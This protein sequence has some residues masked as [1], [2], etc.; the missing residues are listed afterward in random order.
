VVQHSISVIPRTVNLRHLHENSAV[1]LRNI[2]NLNDNQVRTVALSVEAMISE[3]DLPD[4]AFVKIAFHA[5]SKDV[6]LWWYDQE[7]DGEIQVAKIDQ[8]TTWEEESHP[9][10]LYRVYD[11]PE[12]KSYEL[13]AV[14]GKYGEHRYVE[15]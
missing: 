13:F 12:K 7:Y 1:Q 11:G 9:G 10:H 14:E 15:L 5:K 4:D 8:G 6:Y 2:P 3:E